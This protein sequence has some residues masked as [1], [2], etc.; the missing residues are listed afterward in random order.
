MAPR[1]PSPPDIAVVH[2]W[3]DRAAERVRA[4]A[5]DLVKVIGDYAGEAHF[6]TDVIAADLAIAGPGARILEVG[7]GSGLLSAALQSAGFLVTALEPLGSGFSHMGRLRAIVLDLARADACLPETLDSPAEYLEGAGPFDL[8]FSINVMEHVAD[9]AAVLRRVVASLR[10]GGRYRFVCPNYTFPFEPHFNIPTLGTKARTWRVF[11]RRIVTS[12]VVVDPAGTWASLNWISVGSVRRACRA[13]GL[14]PVFDRDITATF[15]R[16]ALDDPTFQR[17]HG[18]AM[19]AAAGIVRGLRLDRMTALL[20][21]SAHPAMSC[22]I[23]R[24]A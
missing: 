11:E 1:V 6:G 5:P 9:P 15:L 20:P 17:R 24:P 2:A 16:R 18:A 3:I 4:A 22:H 10:P 21:P 14:V 23:V 7:A 19:R 8:A 12:P 13:A